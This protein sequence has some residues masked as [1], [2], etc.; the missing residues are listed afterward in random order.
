[1][2]APAPSRREN[3]ALTAVF[4]A[5]LAGHFYCATLNWKVPFMSGHEFRQAQTAIVSYYIDRQD[6]FSLLYETPI[7][8]KP[9]VSVLLEVPLYEWSVV[10]LSRA[11]GIPHYEAARTISLACFY[12][13]L[14]A[15]YLLLGRFALPRPRRLLIL[16]LILTCPVYIYYSRAFLMDSMEL[17]CC[18]WFLLGFVRTMDGRRWPWLVATAVAGTGAALIKSATLAVW[19]L[20][21]AGYGG[22]LLW[23]D[24]RAGSGGGAAVR[25]VLWGVATVAVPLGLLRCW[26]SYTDPIKAVHPSAF[27]FTSKGVAQGNWGLFDFTVIFTR[28]IWNYLL[29]GWRQAIMPPGLIG[30]G[31]VAGG[32]FLPAGR[33]RLLGLAGLFLLPQL[34]FPF[35]YAYQDYY[36][37]SC[38]VFVL[39]A[40][41]FGLVG[42]LD[43]RVSRW[44]CG[45][46]IAVPFIAQMGNYWLGYRVD[47][48]AVSP[49]ARP[50][51]DALRD[52]TP[53][54]SVIVVA[55]ADWAAMTPLYSQRKAL[56]IRNGLE[57]DPN[58]L[59]RAFA[60]LADE[61]VSA[62]VLFGPLRTNRIFLNLAA[63]A[64]D[65]DSSA[66]TFSH[67]VA[68]VYLKRPYIDGC[69]RRLRISQKYGEITIPVKSRDAKPADEPFPIPPTVARTAFAMVSPAPFRG[70]F[71]FGIDLAEDA[72][73]TVL[74]AHPDAD[75][76]LRAPAGATH[77]TW[78]Y[79]IFSTA[80]ERLGGMT[81]GVEFIITGETPGGHRRV[82]YQRLL[83]P[84]VHSADRGRQHEI[85]RYAPL[86]EE[87]LQFS[88][89]PNANPSFDWAYWVR[90]E[91]K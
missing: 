16:A 33:W 37:Y 51:D 27:I 52:L 15:L 61:D 58:Y 72:G 88:T 47:Q 7:V 24:L 9:W 35:A 69:Q 59:K 57:F 89:R 34:M 19:L 2:S 46:V 12:F 85:I 90:I 28:S 30:A 26:I 23:R 8:G 44:V 82:V 80:Y 55:G 66:P 25:T 63:A 38:A 14:P 31:L 64:F 74:S 54:N 22:W 17:M 50:Y 39:A 60:D 77:I 18:A 41:G 84:V 71:A 3:W 68:D 36:F 32:T 29:G 56:M 78:D 43:T 40:L 5:A 11:A 13:A 4:C 65:L 48:L 45:L 79:G 49:G 73:D 70:H 21:A 62:L 75:L 87:T 83:D 81:D 20:P 91:V 6:N 42:V 53:R 86:P 1:M 76:W 10:A 67:T